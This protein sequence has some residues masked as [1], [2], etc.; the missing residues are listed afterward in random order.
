MATGM[1]T[2]RTKPSRR[3]PSTSRINWRLLTFYLKSPAVQSL[4]TAFHAA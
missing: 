3:S 1:S 2:V 4:E